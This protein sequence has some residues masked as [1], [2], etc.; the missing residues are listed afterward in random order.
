MKTKTFLF[1]TIIS[2]LIGCEESVENSFKGVAPVGLVHWNVLSV[3]GP[4]IG[5]VNKAI[6]FNVSCPTTSGCDYVSTFVT[7]DSNG[8]TILI[9]AYGNT[10]KNAMCTQA[11]M[12]IVVKYEFTPHAKGQYVLKFINRDETIVKRS[13]TA[14]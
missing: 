1:V 10:T 7:D 6:T 4:T 11:A 9:K 14:N 2:L 12:P 13:F 5:E 8:N 3:E